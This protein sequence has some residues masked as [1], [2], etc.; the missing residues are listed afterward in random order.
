MLTVFL[1]CVPSDAHAASRSSVV[2][3]RH[4]KSSPTP[5]SLT[6]CNRVSAISVSSIVGRGLPF[7]ATGS[8]DSTDVVAGVS[9]VTVLCE[10]GSGQP[11]D[12]FALQH[13][14]NSKPSSFVGQT[15]ESLKREFPHSKFTF[16]LY[17]GFG[18]GVTGTYITTT[19]DDVVWQ[20]LSGY[21]GG[22]VSFG[23][24][25]HSK[26]TAPVSVTKLAALAK[27][28]QKL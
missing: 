14:T 13:E 18:H 19:T 15:R 26:T 6:V 10:Y 20:S 2:N 3:Q 21:E 8:F 28:A 4:E 23:A 27:L 7:Y 5:K 24:S 12:V 16:A 1:G 11:L 22:L 9:E 17:P 25:V